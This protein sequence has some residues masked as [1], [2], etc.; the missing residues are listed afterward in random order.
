[1]IAIAPILNNVRK[2]SPLVHCLTN[3]VTVNDVANVLLAAGASPIMAD[4]AQEM[5]DITRL[6]NATVLNIG[7]LNERVLSSMQ[8]AGLAAH[9]KGHPVILDPVGAGATRFRTES[10]QR[11]LHDVA[12]TVIR[13][14]ISEILALF[15]AGEASKGVDVHPDDHQKLADRTHWIPWLEQQAKAAHTVLAVT[16]PTDVITDGTKTYLV[17]NGHP[18]MATITGSGCQLSALCAAYAAS[19]DDTVE[20]I[21]AAVATMGVVGEEAVKTLGE[22]VGNLSLRGAIIDAIATADPNHIERSARIE[23]IKSS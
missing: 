14:N 23:T 15:S 9:Q 2:T 5:E 4:E 3:V 20:A 17:H 13:G 11:L 12:P 6:A 22:P 7:T 21:V 10:S 16:G 19:W 8:L 1:M 18:A